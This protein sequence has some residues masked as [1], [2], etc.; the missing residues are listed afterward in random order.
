[1][2]NETY[3]MGGAL[4]CESA[5]ETNGILRPLSARERQS[6]R[7][8]KKNGGKFFLGMPV[9]GGTQRKCNAGVEMKLKWKR[10]NANDKY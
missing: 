5:N 6:V 2:G 8:R 4:R 9:H 10:Q 7:E 1:M 3:K